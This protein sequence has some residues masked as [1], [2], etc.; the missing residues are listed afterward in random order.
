MSLIFDEE[1]CQRRLHAILS[2]IYQNNPFYGPG[3]LKHVALVAIFAS[4]IATELGGNGQVAHLSGWLHDIG[5]AM[6]GPEDH[7]K[8]GA[9]I[10]G[11]ILKGIGFPADIIEPVQQCLLTHRGSIESERETIEAKCVASADGFA[12]FCRVSDLFWVA[13]FK[14]GLDAAGAGEWVRAKLQRSWDKML[15]QHQK[16]LEKYNRAG[17]R[18]NLDLLLPLEEINILS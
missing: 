8:T 11:K 9:E 5:A 10:A 2:N 14:L 7:H 16:L 6:K 1:T 15:P 13:F 4:A 3:L 18:G 17:M 12:H